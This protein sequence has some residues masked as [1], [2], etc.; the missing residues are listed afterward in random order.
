MTVFGC[1]RLKIDLKL[2]THAGLYLRL[3]ALGVVLVNLIVVPD[4]DFRPHAEGNIVVF[5]A[6]QST[7]PVVAAH[8]DIL[9]HTS[10]AAWAAPG[11]FLAINIKP[12]AAF[13]VF[14]GFKG[15]GLTRGGCVKPFGCGLLLQLVSF[16]AFLPAETGSPAKRPGAAMHSLRTLDVRLVSA[17]S[18]ARLTSLY[19]GRRPSNG[20]IVLTDMHGFRGTVGRYV[21]TPACPRC[22]GW[23]SGNDKAQRDDA[24]RQQGTLRSKGVRDEK[25]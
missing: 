7:H 2:H 12:H 19:A 17:A 11:L 24:R 16:Y 8:G 9:I 5:D 10:P 1:V 18:V 3:I 4:N 13:L 21:H 23:G 25:L 20:T 22:A 14:P 6:C 15:F